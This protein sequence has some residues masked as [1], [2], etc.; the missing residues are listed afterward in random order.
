LEG[1]LA[2]LSRD[3]AVPLLAQCDRIIQQDGVTTPE[4]AK[5]IEK[6]SQKFQI[7]LST[8]KTQLISG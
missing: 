5:V 2:Q 1:L 4:E 3:F 6:I 8:M 7:N